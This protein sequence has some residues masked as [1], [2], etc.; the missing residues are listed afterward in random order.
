MKI[1]ITGATGYVGAHLINRLI[2]QG[3]FLHV[4]VRSIKKNP[5]LKNSSVAIFEGNILEKESIK[6]Q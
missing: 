4:L 6:K 2:E 1:F 5:Q 3:H